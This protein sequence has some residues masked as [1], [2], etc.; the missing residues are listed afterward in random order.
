M[1]VWKVEYLFV[2]AV[3]AREDAEAIVLD[4][5]LRDA[6]T[7]YIDYWVEG[8]GKLGRTTPALR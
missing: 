1:V 5:Q 6:V 7:G 3:G 2:L 8:V 4:E